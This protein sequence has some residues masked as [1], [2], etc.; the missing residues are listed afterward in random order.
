MVV[1]IGLYVES[2]EG[3]TWQA[4]ERVARRAEALGF[5]SLASSVHVMPLQARGRWALDIWPVM[6]AV[7]LWTERI[8]FGPLVLPI[9]FYPPAQ[10]ARL[11]A[12]IDRLSHG[13]FE[14]G[15]GSGRHLEEHRA[16]GLPFAAHD[17][18]AAMLAEAV[19]VIRLLWSGEP[20]SYDGEWYRLAQ[21]QALPTPVQG[22]LGVAGNSEET[23]RLAATRADEW[24][25]TNSPPGELQERLRRLDELALEAGRQPQ[26]LVRTI[27]SGVVVGRDAGELRQRALRLADLV[28]SLAGQA[29]EAILDRLAREW[30]WW[31]GTPQQVVEQVST[32]LGTG[33]DRLLFQVYDPDDL[34]ALDLLA[35]EAVP[36]LRAASGSEVVVPLTGARRP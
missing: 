35:E 4:W 28:P 32:A 27:M 22:W 25:T 13:R 23:L 29:P 18:R 14:L 12:A 2:Q 17:E 9:T 33:F 3:A 24:Y 10:I 36:S 31:I 1:R 19:D 5:D 20:A 16:F 6:T 15:L 26:A 34:A 11:A 30:A 21:A 8:H 7:A